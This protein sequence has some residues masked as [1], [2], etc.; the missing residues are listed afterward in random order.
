[1][2]ISPRYFVVELGCTLLALALWLHLADVGDPVHRIARFFV[3]FAFVGTLVVL[4]GI[5]LEHML[6]PDRITYP[7]IPTFFVAALLLGDTPRAQLLVGPIV[8]YG[9]VAVTAELGYALMKRE[10]MGYGDAK[11]LALVGAALGWRAAVFAFFAAPFVGLLVLIPLSIARG[12]SLRGVEVP[13][14]PFLAVASVAYVFL[15]PA[16]AA[17]WPR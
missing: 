3:E 7:A 4:S 13:Y 6:I 2:R 8:G 5:D 1:V 11:L 17:L 10:V 16:L 9:L 12:R 14:G 15:A